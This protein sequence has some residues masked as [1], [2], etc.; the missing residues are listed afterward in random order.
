MRARA[1]LAGLL[2]LTLG[3]KIAF[4]REPAPPDTALSGAS[5]EAMLHAAGF[6]TGRRSHALGIIVYGQRGTCRLMVAE[7]DPRGTFTDILAVFGRPFGPLRFV[8]RGALL[9]A[10]PGSATVEYYWQRELRRLG[11]APERHPVYAVAASE[12][13]AVERLP[14]AGIAALP[15]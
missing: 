5:V 12:A 1:L 2:A 14:W 7:Q 10:V 13:C 3:A 9:D 8:W 11:G 15:R 6:A 4:S